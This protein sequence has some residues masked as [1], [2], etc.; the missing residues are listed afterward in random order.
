MKPDSPNLWINEIP[1]TPIP[2]MDIAILYQ[3]SSVFKVPGE[4]RKYKDQVSVKK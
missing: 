4:D 2:P 1:A 3:K